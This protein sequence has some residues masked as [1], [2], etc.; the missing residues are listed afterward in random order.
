MS[1]LLALVPRGIGVVPR[2]GVRVA[3]LALLIVDAQ[4]AATVVLPLDMTEF[5]LELVQHEL[6]PVA[7]ALK[8]PAPPSWIG[9]TPI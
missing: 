2:R 7:D 3:D 8:L 6:K 5:T 9:V 1:P 4:F